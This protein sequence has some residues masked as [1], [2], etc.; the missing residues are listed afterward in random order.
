MSALAPDVTVSVVTD[1]I[2]RLPNRLLLMDRLAHSLDRARRY[3]AFHFALLAID[4]GTPTGPGHSATL[5]DTTLTAVARR[6]ETCLRMPEIPTLRNNDLVAR[7]DGH[8]FAILL[9]GLKDIGHAKT[10]ADR[11]LNELLNPFTIGGR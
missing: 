9:D 1:P 4:L 5:T 2:T 3:K 10:A 8:L 7:V 11:I 6:L